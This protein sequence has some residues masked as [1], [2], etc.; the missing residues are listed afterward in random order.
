MRAD[1]V[2]GDEDRRCLA[3][4]PGEKKIVAEMGLQTGLD[5]SLLLHGGSIIFPLP[6]GFKL[7]LTHSLGII[8]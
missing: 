2:Q 5:D 4:L 6:L 8:K 7:Y 1:K 3:G